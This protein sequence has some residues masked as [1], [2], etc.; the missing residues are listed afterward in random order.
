MVLGRPTL[1]PCTH[2]V[3]RYGVCEN[4]LLEKL[5]A[6]ITSYACPLDNYSQCITAKREYECDCPVCM[7]TCLREG[8]FL[9]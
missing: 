9:P 4:G 5:L 3:C 1:L 6:V 7:T 2:I 8:M